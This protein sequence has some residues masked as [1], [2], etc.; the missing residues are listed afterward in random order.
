[1]YRY[2][3]LS[4]FLSY[5]GFFDYFT[6]LGMIHGGSYFGQKDGSAGDERG[7]LWVWQWV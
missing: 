7:S 4:Y 1:M 2:I 5:L 6:S 3:N